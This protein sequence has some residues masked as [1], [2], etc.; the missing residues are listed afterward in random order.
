M[1]YIVDQ[2][3]GQWILVFYGDFIESTIVNI[4]PLYAIFLR[5]KNDRAPLVMS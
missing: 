1:H 5:D 4:H 3:E 2:T